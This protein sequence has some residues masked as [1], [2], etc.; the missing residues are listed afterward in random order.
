MK[1]LSF[2]QTQSDQ[3]NKCHHMEVFCQVIV[4]TI[5]FQCLSN[6]VHDCAYHHVLLTV[7][8]VLMDI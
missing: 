6:L 1:M 5:R 2:A 7:F 3:K 4:M 8:Y